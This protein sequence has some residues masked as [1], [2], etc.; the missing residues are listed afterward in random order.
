M[1]ALIDPHEIYL[2]SLFERFNNRFGP[3]FPADNA[4]AWL[5]GGITE[6]AALQHEF[7]IFKPGRPFVK[8][9]ALLGLTAGDYGPAKERWVAYLEKL[10]RMKSDHDSMTGDERIVD[11]LLQNFQRP[12]GPLPC[13]LQPQDGRMREPGLVTVSHERPLFYLETVEFLT[14]RLPFRPS[15]GPGEATGF[16]K[17]TPPPKN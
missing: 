15:G 10:P 1:G 3:G 8:S 2:G 12:S 5:S 6:I 4:S 17:R 11:A 9:A 13:L 7:E 16:G 14:I